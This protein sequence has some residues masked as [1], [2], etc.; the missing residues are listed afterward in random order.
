[1]DQII[2]FLIIYAIMRIASWIIDQANNLFINQKA[3]DVDKEFSI[4]WRGLLF[5]IP[6]FMFVW[7]SIDQSQTYIFGYGFLGSFL[8]LSIAQA[9]ILELG[10]KLI[11]A[12]KYPLNKN[13]LL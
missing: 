8:I 3:D 5:K 4:F 11:T 2:Q 1:M 12:F 6:L 9:I 10:K 7:N 13:S